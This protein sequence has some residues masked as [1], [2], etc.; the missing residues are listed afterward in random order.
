[1]G[2]QAAARAAPV[3]LAAGARQLLSFGLA[4]ALDPQLGAGT[5]F[6]ADTVLDEAGTAH[7]TC[8]PWRE[9]LARLAAARGVARGVLLSVAQ[10]LLSADA[11]AQAWRTTGAAAVDMESFAIAAVAVRQGVDFAVARVVV[12]TASDALPR[13]VAAATGARGEVNYARLIAGVLGAPQ[14][15]A[16]LLRL[17]RRYRAAM[18]S[19]RFLGRQGVGPA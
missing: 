8:G 10:P 7:A 15:L 6:L 9:R 12:D 18:A 16:A 13:S 2:P 11:K 4:G 17:S 14:D 1:M 3:L 5:V 19:L